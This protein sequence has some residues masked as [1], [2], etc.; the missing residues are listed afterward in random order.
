MAFLA[1]N[2]LP[3]ECNFSEIQASERQLLELYIAEDKAVNT[4]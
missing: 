4:L 3:K 2:G 1:R